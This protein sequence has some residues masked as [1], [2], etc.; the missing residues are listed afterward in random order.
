M[1]RPKAPAERP[2]RLAVLS[3]APR[4]HIVCRVCGRIAEVPLDTGSQLMLEQLAMRRP[5]GW[6]VDLVSFSLT[7]AC[8]R[9]RQGRRASP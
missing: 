1:V 2:Q 4:G 7:G 5:D 8:A 9:C 3:E 6:S